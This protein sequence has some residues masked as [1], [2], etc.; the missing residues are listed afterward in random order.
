[1]KDY[2]KTEAGLKLRYNK[3]FKILEKISKVDF[4]L[5]LSVKYQVY[6]PVFHASKLTVYTMPLVSG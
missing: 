1:M 4:K 6:Y 3:L 2:Q 5:D